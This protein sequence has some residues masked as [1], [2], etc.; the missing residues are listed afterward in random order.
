MYVVVANT[1]CPTANR[2][3]WF[4][5]TDKRLNIIQFCFLSTYVAHLGFCL[6]P[7]SSISDHW[8]SHR[9]LSVCRWLFWNGKGKIKINSTMVNVWC[10]LFYDVVIGPYFFKQPVIKQENVLIMLLQ[11]ALPHPRVIFQLDGARPHLGLGVRRSLERRVSW[12]VDRTRFP[13]STYYL[14]C[15]FGFFSSWLCKG[16]S[17]Q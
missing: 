6:R 15:T 16:W 10:G 3:C 9:V 1:N 2:R 4:W 8:S 12:S 17:V 13:N 5:I 7:K 14:C 11:F